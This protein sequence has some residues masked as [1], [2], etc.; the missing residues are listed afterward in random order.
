MEINSVSFGEIEI[1][2]KKYYSDM[3]VWW[4][5]RVDYRE[6]S[7]V[8]TLDEFIEILKRGP[9]V[10]VVGTGMSGCVQVEDRARELA[11]QKGIGIYT[12]ISPKAAEIFNGFV[13]RGKRAVAVI[14]TTC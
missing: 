2:G 4:D 10:L 6:K 11:E 5:G 13:K 1:S 9:K 8:L 3:L 14:H 7:H 12:E